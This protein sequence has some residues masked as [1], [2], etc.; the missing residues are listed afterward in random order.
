MI[1]VLI[2]A[3][4][5]SIAADDMVTIFGEVLKL[6]L[7]INIR[8]TFPSVFSTKSTTRPKTPFAQ[9]STTSIFFGNKCNASANCVL[10]SLIFNSIY[11]K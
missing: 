7:L 1:Y 2:S 11:S 4:G 8:Q 10:F 6:S 3:V 5:N 9:P